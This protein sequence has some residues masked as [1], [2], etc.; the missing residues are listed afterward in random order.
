M[1]VMMMIFLALYG[2]DWE[3]DKKISEK[4]KNMVGERNE[5]P[6]GGEVILRVDLWP[7]ITMSDVFAEGAGGMAFSND[8]IYDPQSFMLRRLKL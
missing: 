6:G 1:T 3:A 4:W 8:K 2:T 7:E 5:G